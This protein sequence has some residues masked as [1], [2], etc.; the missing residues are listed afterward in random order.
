[1][2]VYLA[3]PMRDIPEF[4]F[5]AFMDAAKRLRAAGFEVFNPAER[6][7]SEF[8]KVSE[9]TGDEHEF[10]KI[11][12]LTTM[13]LRRNCFLADTNWI[14][15]YADGIVLLPGWD[16]SKGARAELALS[17]A[18]GLE[19]IEYEDWLYE[20]DNDLREAYDRD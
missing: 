11:V 5:P 16:D 19:V 9:P 4:N 3:G 13:D 7:E 14:C 15:R 10:A 12:G 1:M 18:L 2:K 8:G 6:D 20:T 17:E